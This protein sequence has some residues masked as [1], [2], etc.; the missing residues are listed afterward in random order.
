MLLRLLGGGPEG[1]CVKVF[2]TFFWPADCGNISLLDCIIK[3]NHM[4]CQRYIISD[5]VHKTYWPPGFIKYV[6]TAD[7]R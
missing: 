6:I 5:L 3:V 1:A 4:L 7:D 2:D